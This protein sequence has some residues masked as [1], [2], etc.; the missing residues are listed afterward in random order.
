M[1]QP[2]EATVNPLAA[3]AQRGGCIENKGGSV[4]PLP[5]APS[6]RELKLHWMCEKMKEERWDMSSAKPLRIFCGTWNVNCKVLNSD[7]GESL[8]P[9]LLPADHAPSDIYAIGFQEIVELNPYNVVVTG[10]ESQDKSIYWFNQVKKTLDSSSEQFTLIKSDHIVGISLCIFAKDSVSP[11]IS[12]VRVAITRIGILGLLGNKG[13]VTIRLNVYNSTMAFVCSHLRAQQSAVVGRNEDYSAILGRTILHPNPIN[14]QAEDD[15]T[16]S[17]QWRLVDTEKELQILEHDFIFWLGDLNYRVDFS[18]KM[19]L[20]ELLETINNGDWSQILELDQLVRQ[21]AI[22][23]V[24]SGF[25]EGQITF[26]PTYKFQPGTNRYE[27][28]PDKKKRAPAWCDRVLWKDTHAATN[29]KLGY[30]VTQLLY[31][32]AVELC[33]SD[34]K[35]VMSIFTCSALLCTN[36]KERETYTKLL[37]IMDKWENYNSPKMSVEGNVID[38][39]SIDVDIPVTKSITIKNT[40]KCPV[41]WFFVPKADDTMISPSWFK[42]SVLKGILEP[43]GE[44]LVEIIVDV[45]STN[46]E[47]AA[48]DKNSRLQEIV[49]IRV[50][51]GSDFFVIIDIKRVTHSKR[52]SALVDMGN[53]FPN[54]D[55]H[56]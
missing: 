21:R 33:P 6:N 4:A 2:G 16:P 48:I 10:N 17:Q 28:R 1:S 37:N 20:P 25:N 43:G 34:H 36:D 26:Q 39:E 50:S 53:V 8:H 45:N 11:A 15:L 3:E 55:G 29:S 42:I 19:T 14:T 38:I 31:A 47:L 49:V 18:E 41:A 51:G 46:Q 7:V 12:D 44:K 32:S 27:Q 54:N 13:A 5:Y 40:G 9:W 56:F 30:G 23:N 22:G 24:F 35:P 52:Q